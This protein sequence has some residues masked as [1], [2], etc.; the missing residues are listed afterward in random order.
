MADV[1]INDQEFG[2]FHSPFEVQQQANGEI[3]E[4]LQKEVNKI[5]IC[6]KT[7]RFSS[8]LIKKNWGF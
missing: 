5:E 4:S 7:L 8:N 1:L 2:D 6:S 3:C